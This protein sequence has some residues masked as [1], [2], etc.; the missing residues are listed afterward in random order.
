MVRLD[1]PIAER[2]TIGIGTVAHGV[3][4]FRRNNMKRGIETFSDMDGK[5]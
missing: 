2:R 4:G 3:G 5:H 1:C